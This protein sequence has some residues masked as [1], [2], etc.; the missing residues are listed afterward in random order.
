M[1]A[2]ASIP[3]GDP[4]KSAAVVADFG[5]ARSLTGSY[6]S[7]FATHREDEQDDLT[8]I[9]YL[10]IATY[11]GTV[12]F[13][14]CGFAYFVKKLSGL[15]WAQVIHCQESDSAVLRLRLSKH[16]Q[17]IPAEMG[18]M[19]EVSTTRNSSKSSCDRFSR[20]RSNETSYRARYQRTSELSHRCN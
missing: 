4:N 18:F 13:L 17:D 10:V 8:Q 9:G 3:L 11:A 16:G 15:G 12:I 2:V 1:T 7:E 14:T 5:R 19:G 6:A 20:R